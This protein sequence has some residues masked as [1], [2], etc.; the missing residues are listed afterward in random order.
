MLLIVGNGV[1]RSLVLC[2]ALQGVVGAS[3]VIACGSRGAGA[4]HSPMGSI[5]V[6]LPNH[7]Y[8]PSVCHTHTRN[9]AM[10]NSTRVLLWSVTAAPSVW[11]PR[12]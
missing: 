4:T 5:A 1:M 10:Y 6:R 9:C 11:P 7:T 12:L 3:I 8:E 2:R